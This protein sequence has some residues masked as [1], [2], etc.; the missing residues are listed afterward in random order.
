MAQD[1]I[2]KSL[3]DCARLMPLFWGYMSVVVAVLVLVNAESTYANN[4]SDEIFSEAMSLHDDYALKLA[5]SNKFEAI[6]AGEKLAEYL[7][8][9]QEILDNG[10]IKNWASDTLVW[11]NANRLLYDYEKKVKASNKEG[12]IAAERRLE[13]YL[14]AYQEVLVGEHTVSVKN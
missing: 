7:E 3:K 6:A 8:E 12:A 11:I 9:N 1:R 2:V 13:S 10:A 4:K 14:N 5:S